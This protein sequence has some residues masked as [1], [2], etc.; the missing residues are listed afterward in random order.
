MMLVRMPMI[1]R[2]GMLVFV[3]MRVFMRIAVLVGMA[4]TV[5]VCMRLSG[6]MRVFVRMRMC[7]LVRMGVV[8]MIAMRML[9]LSAF[10]CQHVDLRA[11]QT[12]ADDFTRLDP[13]SH[14]ECRSGFRQHRYRNP[15][16]HHG[17][18]Q[19]VAADAGKAVQIGNTHRG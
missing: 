4:M 5:R 2:I 3:Q 14:I 8:G 1:V 13:R 18:Q 12:A 10:A 17:A 6:P 16:I 19:H 9:R 11:G 15:R 7:V